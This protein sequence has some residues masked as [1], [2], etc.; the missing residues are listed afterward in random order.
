MKTERILFLLKWMLKAL[1]FIS[2]KDILEKKGL[3]KSL[4]DYIKD[5]ELLH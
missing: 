4:E 2:K 5:I 1:T 3:E